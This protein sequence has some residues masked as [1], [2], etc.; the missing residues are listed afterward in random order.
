MAAI[1]GGISPGSDRM[2]MFETPIGLVWLA[3]ATDLLV[4]SQIQTLWLKA[5]NGLIML[6]M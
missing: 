5:V 4:L 1:I 6:S 3:L 2:W